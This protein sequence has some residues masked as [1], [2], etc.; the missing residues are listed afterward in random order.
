MLTSMACSDVDLDTQQQA[1]ERDTSNILYDFRVEN[2][3][4]L[5]CEEDGCRIVGSASESTFVDEETLWAALDSESHRVEEYRRPQDQIST[6]LSE[7]AEE[8]ADPIVDKCPAGG[9]T[10]VISTAS[11]NAG[12]LRK[13]IRLTSPSTQIHGRCLYARMV[14][15]NIPSGGWKVWAATMAYSNTPELH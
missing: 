1:Q 9:G 13:K 10:T 12:A 7:W 4:T 3:N 15:L 11:E 5:A 2:S 8:T 6:D 14:G